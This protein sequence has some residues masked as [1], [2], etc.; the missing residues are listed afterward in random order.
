[1]RIRTGKESGKSWAEKR[2]YNPL[3]FLT[4]LKGKGFHDS[5]IVQCMSPVVAQRRSGE[6]LGRFLLFAVNRT[7][8]ES[9][10]FLIERRLGGYLQ[11]LFEAR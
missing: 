7:L 8:I 5:L 10:L 1:V 11:I 6:Q 9:P 3:Y 2:P 4:A